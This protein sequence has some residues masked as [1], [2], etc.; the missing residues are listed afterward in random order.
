MP[1]VRGVMYLA[2]CW[3][4]TVRGYAVITAF[5]LTCAS[6]IAQGANECIGNDH[7][8]SH[9]EGKNM[10]IPQIPCLAYSAPAQPIPLEY[11]QL[12]SF[13]EPPEVR[14]ERAD[15]G[16]FISKSSTKQNMY[17]FT[18][19]HANTSIPRRYTLYT[20]T[21]T[22]RTKWYN[23][24]VDAIGVRKA[25]QDANMVFALPRRSSA[26][27]IIKPSGMDHKRLTMAFSACLRAPHLPQGCILLV[28]SFVPLTFVG[29]L[30]FFSSINIDGT[31]SIS[32]AELLCCR[33]YERY[34]RW[35][36]CRVL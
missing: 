29:L 22:A 17:A 31:H 35:Y 19:Y 23:A 4:T 33:L 36:P 12:A 8:Q 3:T 18:V 21:P 15:N 26:C 2:P 7:A 16:S 1:G 34:I 28:V 14:K 13:D 24:L 11:L 32:K 25:R 6:L 5:G 30:A 20:L 10:T 9:S 27:L